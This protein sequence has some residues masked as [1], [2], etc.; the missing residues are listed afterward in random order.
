MS[1]ASTRTMEL[2]GLLQRLRTLTRDLGNETDFDE[3]VGV[4]RELWRTIVASRDAL[5]KAKS[6]IRLGMNDPRPGRHIIQ[7][8]DGAFCTVV[9]PRTRI[10]MRKGAIDWTNL[11]HEVGERTVDELFSERTVRTPS[12]KFESLVAGMS[13]NH[14][15]LV[16][17]CVD[18]VSGKPRVSFSQ[19]KKKGK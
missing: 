16:L 11:R 13:G 8:A 12:R 1:P 15:Q 17:A 7:G 14:R 5:E 6:R 19:A 18:T 4:G 9:I 3:A 2:R 10:V